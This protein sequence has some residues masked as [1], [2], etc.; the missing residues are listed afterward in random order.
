MSLKPGTH[1]GHHQILSL[2]G[3][4][5]MGG[6]YRARDTKLKRDVG[7]G[8]LTPL[9]LKQRIEPFTFLPWGIV[10]TADRLTLRY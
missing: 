9:S 7:G 3:V 5:G 8:I 1:L 10:L 4:G 2:I 6:V